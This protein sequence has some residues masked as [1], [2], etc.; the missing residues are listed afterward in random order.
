MSDQARGITGAAARWRSAPRFPV[1]ELNSGPFPGR[2]ESRSEI[3]S[4]TPIF[5][6]LTIGGWRSRH[7]EGP[8]PPAT[9]RPVSAVRPVAVVD[10]VADFRHDPLTAPI[11]VP[12]PSAVPIPEQAVIPIRRAAA[13]AK[14]ERTGGKHR[15]L[16]PV[17]AAE[18]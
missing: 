16:S 6:A 13:H 14:P 8:V 4:E 1:S 3:A 7:H 9:L 10:V 15:Q 5:H 11:P 2:H 12:G 18:W 17:Q